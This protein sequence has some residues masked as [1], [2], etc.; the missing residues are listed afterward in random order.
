MLN[1]D[2]STFNNSINGTNGIKGN[3][4]DMEIELINICKAF[5]E[6]MPEFKNIR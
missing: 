6:E 5:I 3:L 2:A 1:F 4:E